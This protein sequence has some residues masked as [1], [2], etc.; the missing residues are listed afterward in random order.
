[1]QKPIYGKL[2][3]NNK[4]YPF[5]LEDHI[6]FIVQQ[7]FEYRDDF[8]NFDNDTFLYG[9]TSNNAYIVF[10]NSKISQTVF[11]ANVFF[12]IQGYILYK[13]QDIDDQK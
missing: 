4:T 11:Q 8:K 6:V 2:Y 7:A 10:L 3:Y 5:I 12:S 9:V 1:M 13:Q